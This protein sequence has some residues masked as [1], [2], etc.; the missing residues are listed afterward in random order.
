MAA[1]FDIFCF[2]IGGSGG[3]GS[4]VYLLGQGLGSSLYRSNN[5]GIGLRSDATETM[6]VRR[7]RAVPQERAVNRLVTRE[8][9][10][11]NFLRYS[12]FRES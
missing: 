8:R 2:L 5:W 12:W 7:R 11:N 4:G 3:E 6:A 10:V 1:S 9:P